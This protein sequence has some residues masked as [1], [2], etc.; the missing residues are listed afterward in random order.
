MRRVADAVRITAMAIYRHYRDRDAL[1]NTLADTGFEELARALAS[2]RLPVPFE[3]RLFRMA[4]VY[5]DHSLANP[6]LFELMFLKR[7]RGARR[8][9]RDFKAGRSPT[10]NLFAEVVKQGM[11]SGDLRDDDHWEITFELGALIEGLIM[12]YLGGRMEGRPAQLRALL[13]RSLRRYLH[14]IRR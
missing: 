5:L 7:R 1:L 11:E 3:Q 14:G 13:R 10:A 12:L 4:E 6:R 8:F 9:P 2:K